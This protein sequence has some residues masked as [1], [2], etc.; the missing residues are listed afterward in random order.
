V[1]TASFPRTAHMGALTIV[2]QEGRRSF[3]SPRP[4]SQAETGI[5]KSVIDGSFSVEQAADAHARFEY[6]KDVGKVILTP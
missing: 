1:A 5:V 4:G 2:K 6:G 3:K